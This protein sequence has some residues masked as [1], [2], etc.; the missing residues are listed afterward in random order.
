M[1]SKKSKAVQFEDSPDN[2]DNAPDNNTASAP[3]TV[4]FKELFGIF[5]TEYWAGLCDAIAVGHVKLALD[6]SSTVRTVISKCLMLNGVLFVGFHLI[7]T[8][9]MTPVIQE[10]LYNQ[11]QHHYHIN[12]FVNGVH[13]ILVGSY[14]VRIERTAVPLYCVVNTNHI[15]SYRPM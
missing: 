11:L 14:Y 1:S 3:S 12:M 2:K 10:L 9:I 6:R 15:T 8:Y 5:F 13:Y 4:G 7:F